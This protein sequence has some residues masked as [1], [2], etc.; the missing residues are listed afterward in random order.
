LLKDIAVSPGDLYNAACL[1]SRCSEL[2]DELDDKEKLALR[3]VDLL[4]QALKKGFDDAALLKRDPDFKTIRNRMDFQK[5]AAQLELA[6]PE[7]KK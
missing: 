5:V 6:V 3:A 1:Y 4:N 7:N 2:M